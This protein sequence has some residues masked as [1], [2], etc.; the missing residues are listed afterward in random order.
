MFFSLSL[1]LYDIVNEDGYLLE[2][3]ELSLP[4]AR[5]DSTSL[6]QLRCG[7]DPPAPG[8]AGR[9]T[10]PTDFLQLARDMKRF[11]FAG[12]SAPAHRQT[13][14]TG[15]KFRQRSTYR[16]RYR[17]FLFFGLLTK[18]YGAFAACRHQ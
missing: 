16:V 17:C 18:L 10:R 1:S 11:F 13:R 9:L 3:F 15:N 2:E 14:P 5:P 4:A 7:T 6:A 8:L 12:C